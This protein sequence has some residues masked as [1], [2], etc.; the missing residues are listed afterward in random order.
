[1]TGPEDVVL[2]QVILSNSG[3]QQVLLVGDH[4]A[5]LGARLQVLQALSFLLTVS[6][7]PTTC[8]FIFNVLGRG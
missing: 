5:K 6:P 3:T 1:M 4:V 2:A 7:G 8:V